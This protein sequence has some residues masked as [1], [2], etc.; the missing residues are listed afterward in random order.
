MPVMEKYWKNQQTSL[1]G[2][3]HHGFGREGDGIGRNLGFM[4]SHNRRMF[5]HQDLGDYQ[6]ALVNQGLI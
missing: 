2:Y 1:M 4:D 6:G 3:Y 5:M